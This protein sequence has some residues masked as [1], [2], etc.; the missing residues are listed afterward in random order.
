MTDV[1]ANEF[2]AIV[3]DASVGIAIVRDEPAAAGIRASVAR[4]ARFDR[5]MVVPSL[6]WIEVLNPLARKHRFTSED[7]L[8]AVDTLEE[9]T[10]TTIDPDRT[11]LLLTVD[12][13]ERYELT[14]YDAHY[15][16]LAHQLG[17]DLATLDADLLRAAGP[18]GV[19]PDGG[20][21]L[22]ETP[23]AYEHDVTWPDYKHA[24]A[25]LAKLRAEALAGRRA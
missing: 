13:I 25:Y 21:R 24:S 9:L 5:E 11:L 8:R 16:A 4:W 3:L 18:H 17:A 19:S 1:P 22:H 23:A 20:H 7:L 10:L 15:L 2:P 6:F 12:H 14:A